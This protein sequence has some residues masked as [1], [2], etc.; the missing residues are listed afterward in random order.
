MNT[1]NLKRLKQF[2]F[3]LNCLFD[4]LPVNKR[5]AILC[6]LWNVLFLFYLLFPLLPEIIKN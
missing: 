1:T 4:L 5:V 3:Y 6:T 2:R